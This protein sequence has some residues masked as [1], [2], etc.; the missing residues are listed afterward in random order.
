[1]NIVDDN[2]FNLLYDATKID[3]LKRKKRS[4]HSQQDLD[5]IDKEIN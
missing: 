2:F 3:E 4:P 5:Q 1:M